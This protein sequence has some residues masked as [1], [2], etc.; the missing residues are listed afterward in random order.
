MTDR[1][2]HL[3]LNLH[4]LHVPSLVNSTYDMVSLNPEREAFSY[5]HLN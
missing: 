3:H 5:P 4:L 1:Q 2:T